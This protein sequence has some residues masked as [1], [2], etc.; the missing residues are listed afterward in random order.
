MNQENR[1]EENESRMLKI[2]EEKQLAYAKKQYFMSCVTA[3]ISAAMLIIVAVSMLS[4]NARFNNIYKSL[5]TV[6]Q[7][8][9]EITTELADADLGGMVKE[10]DSLAKNSQTSLSEAMEKLNAIDIET[11]NSSIAGLNT[12]VK[13]FSGLFGMF[14]GRN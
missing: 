10:I 14:G 1:L 5:S 3:A 6:S 13:S 12:A 4:F 2:L 8:L 11:L 9:E 7:N